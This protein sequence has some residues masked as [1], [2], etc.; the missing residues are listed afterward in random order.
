[1]SRSK[2]IVPT[3]QLNVYSFIVEEEDTFKE[4]YFYTTAER[5]RRHHD[6][7][8]STKHIKVLSTYIRISLFPIL[9]SKI[10]GGRTAFKHRVLHTYIGIFNLDHKQLKTGWRTWWPSC[11]MTEVRKAQN[12]YR[13]DIGSNLIYP[14][15]IKT[16]LQCYRWLLAEPYVQKQLGHDPRWKPREV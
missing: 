3:S 5:K 4:A 1:M 6:E 7:T 9:D 11:R 13:Y 14:P 16:D 12:S 15:S 10:I 2:L 8:Y